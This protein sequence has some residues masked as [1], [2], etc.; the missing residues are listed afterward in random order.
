MTDPI[1]HAATG[2]HLAPSVDELQHMRFV[3]A[4]RTP[5]DAIIRGGKVLALHTGEVLTRDVVIAGRFIAAVTPVGHMQAATVIDA[6]GLFVAPGFIDTHLHIEYTKLVPGELA[7]LSVPRGT[8]T[9]LAD[10]NCIANVLG[11]AG[12]DFMGQT[13]TPLRIFRQVSHK[14]PQAPELELGGARLTTEQIAARVQR[15]EAATLGESN[16]FNLEHAAAR[17]QVA[18]LAAGKRITGHTALLQNEPLWGYLAGGISDDHNAHVTA[19]VV[20]RLRLGRMI[21]VMSGSMNCNVPHVFADLAA[22]GDGLAHISFCADD[23]LVEDI[24]RDGHIDH[25]VR[26]A[27]ACGVPPIWAWRMATLNA[28]IHYRLDHLL[29]AVVPGRLAD[30]QLVPDLAE[31]RPTA[32]I[33]DGRLVARDGQ[34]LFENTD[35]VPPVARGTVHLAPQLGP[36][37]FAVRANGTGAWVHAMEMYDGYFKR[38]F[39]ARLPVETG[40]VRC[41]VARDILKVVIVDR[42]HA[43][44]TAGV[45]FVKGFGLKRGAIAATTN[46][47]NQN[48]VMIGTSDEELAH[49]ARAIEAIGGGYVVVAEGEVLATVPLPVAGC[50]S[51]QPWEVVRDQSL[52]C[53]AAARA[54]GC[55]IHAPFLIMS[56]VGLVG[57]PDLGLTERG[58]VETATQSFLELVL[59]EDGGIAAC[60]CPSHAAEVHKIMDPKTY[61]PPT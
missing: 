37:T 58:L 12:L 38:A 3:A 17:K 41:D 7:R 53:D 26:R 43:T 42:H 4:G 48:L 52:A 9:V 24:A 47:E 2:A 20:E 57:V 28:A 13:G 16:P 11:E 34:P 32:V 5:P 40:T 33:V 1:T 15:P 36:A 51:D 21:T 61:T 8:T 19:D 54:I 18:A 6:T 25:H 29:G 55:T 27:I 60:R 30:L 14:V 10:A 56:F 35:P 23:K 45:G 50:M 46:C 59:T 49:A 44:Q 31:V 39:H 22:L